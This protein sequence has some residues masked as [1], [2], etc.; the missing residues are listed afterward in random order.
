M[1][2]DDAATLA[3]T[4]MDQFGLSHVPF[5]F[6]G[7]KRRLGCTRFVRATGQILG[8]SLSRHY[9]V[10]LPEDEIR[11][12]ILHEIA[13]ALAGARNGHNYIWMRIAREVGAKPERCA[14]PTASP[15]TAIEGRCPNGHTIGFHRMP[16]RV[17]SCVKCSPNYNFSYAFTY[18]RKGKVVRISDM[19]SKYREEHNRLILK[20]AK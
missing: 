8:I 19:P 13:H 11:D 1:D 9:T 14:A 20:Y 17:K 6:D 15:D 5:E 16:Q 2:I 12:V 10:L 3:R 18:Y 7:G 4:L